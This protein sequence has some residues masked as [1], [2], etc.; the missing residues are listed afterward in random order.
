MVERLGS[1]NIYN[2]RLSNRPIESL[3]R[4]L[5]EHKRLGRGY[6]NLDH[7]R[8]RF[9]YATRD[10]PI[11]NDSPLVDTIIDCIAHDSYRINITSIDTK[12]DIS[13]RKV[14]DLDKTLRK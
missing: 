9:L 6:Q 14:Y 8:A 10:N 5:K 13:M 4:K 7:F 1:G 2:S 11:L 12:H 3:N